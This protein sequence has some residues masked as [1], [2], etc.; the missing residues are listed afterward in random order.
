M[1][2]F[3]RAG[4]QHVLP[5]NAVAI[6]DSVDLV[7]HAPGGPVVVRNGI[8]NGNELTESGTFVLRRHG[9]LS[10]LFDSDVADWYLDG[11]KFAEDADAAMDLV[12]RTADSLAKPVLDCCCGFGRLSVKMLARGVEVYGVDISERSVEE[13]LAATEMAG[14]DESF[15]PVVA[16]IANFGMPGFFGAAISVANSLRYLGSIGRIS[17]HLQLIGQ[18]LV[19]GA[20]YVIEVD[21]NSTVG[22]A[23]WRI[24]H[25]EMTWEVLS[26][27]TFAQ[28]STER[29]TIRDPDGTV[30]HRE[31]QSQVAID[32]TQL[33]ELA[34][35]AGFTLREAWDKHCKPIEKTELACYEG[36]VWYVFDR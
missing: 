8:R 21:T 33:I 12:T 36:N 27:D 10:T 13:A 9:L 2:L 15:H 26:V 30:L 24:P 16:D 19:P 29:V 18:S 35:R 22:G 6:I 23:T 11:E 3:D 14:Y 7:L 25:G 31:L 17:R 20:V 5:S 28:E 32:S 34:L 1:I 4:N